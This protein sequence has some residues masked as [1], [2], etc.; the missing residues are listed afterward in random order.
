[1]D[2][3][4]LFF[5]LC[6]QHVRSVS[7]LVKLYVNKINFDYIYENVLQLPSHLQKLDMIMQLFSA[8]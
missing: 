4:S 6:S 8:R 3:P 7:P 5:K 2:R 1:M